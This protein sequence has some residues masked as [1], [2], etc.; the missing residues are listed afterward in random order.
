MF[1]GIAADLVLTIFVGNATDD[2]AYSPAP[3]QTYL[4]I[5]DVYAD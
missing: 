2:Y 4:A 1:L 3:N 5:D